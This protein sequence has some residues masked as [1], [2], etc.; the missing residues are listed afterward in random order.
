MNKY[1]MYSYFI[2]MYWHL[3]KYII[4]PYNAE[5]HEDFT[6]KLKQTFSLIYCIIW[7]VGN[8]V[9]LFILTVEIVTAT[10]IKLKPKKIWISYWYHW[11][12]HIYQNASIPKITFSYAGI[13]FS[14]NQ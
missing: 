2:L 12:N 6:V 5:G 1:L 4:T 7:L 10:G 13:G 3:L 11:N 9:D 8:T 14:C